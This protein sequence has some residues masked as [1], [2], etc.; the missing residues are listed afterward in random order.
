[1]I[2]L[3]MNVISETIRPEPSEAVMRWM[4]FAPG[5]ELYTTAITEAEMRYGAERRHE[6][7][8]KCDLQNL[9]EKI[10]TV[11]FAGHILPFDSAAAKMFPAILVEM[12]RQDRSGSYFDARSLRL[13]ASTAQASR[14]AIQAA[15][16]AP[17]SS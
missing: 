6:G 5:A 7:K 16:I 2:I 10:F 3:D 1:M 9:V 14:C 15:M 12:Q 8:K 13:R 11:G 4:R 17:V